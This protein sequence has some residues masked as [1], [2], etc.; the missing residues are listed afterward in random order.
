MKLSELLTITGHHAEQYPHGGLQVFIGNNR[1]PR[2]W[3]CSDYVVRASLSGPSLHLVLR[4]APK[5][6]HAAALGRVGGRAR[7]SGL[8]DAERVALASKGGQA[9]ARKC[10]AKRDALNR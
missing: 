5:N 1:D 4:D 3:D 7:Q 10:A 9:F 2:Y 6:P 8:T